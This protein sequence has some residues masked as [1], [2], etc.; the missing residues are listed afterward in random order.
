LTHYLRI[1]IL[2]KLFEKYTVKLMSFH[3]LLNNNKITHFVNFLGIYSPNPT[4]SLDI[5]EPLETG[6]FILTFIANINSQI[7]QYTS[8]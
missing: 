3:N 6:C 7:P 1:I 5:C 4:V 2:G 8:Q